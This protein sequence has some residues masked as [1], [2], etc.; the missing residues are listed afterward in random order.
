M[1]TP[2]GHAL[3]GYAISLLKPA[4][5][6]GSPRTILWLCFLLA[7][8]PDFDFFPGI[9]QGQPALYHQ[10]ISHSFGFALAIGFGA[11]LVFDRRRKSFFVNWTIFSLAYTSHLI[12]DLFGGDERPPLGIPLFWPFSEKSYLAPFQIFLGVR[13][14]ASTSVPTDEWF[15][16]VL[17]HHNLWAIGIE[18]GVL[19]P[20]VFVFWFLRNRKIGLFST[21]S[22]L[23]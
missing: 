3:A 5:Q 6:S 1:A 2:I 12:I 16:S 23:G 18:V 7:I 10:G 20:L 8:A 15:L 14:A 11:A 13:H 21:K 4:P 17:H 22:D 9:L 19:L